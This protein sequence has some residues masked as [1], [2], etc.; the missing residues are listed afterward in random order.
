MSYI[1]AMSYNG[2]SN[3]DTWLVSLWYGDFLSEIGEEVTEDGIRELVFDSMPSEDGF[4][5]DVL[6]S[7]DP[8]YRE[9]AEHYNSEE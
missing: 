2:W 8:D 1:S 3:K 5:G 7:F 9:L 4:W 6:S